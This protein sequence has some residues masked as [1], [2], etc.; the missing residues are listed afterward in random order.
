[1]DVP[2]RL[3]TRGLNCPLPV[4]KAQKALRTMAAGGRLEILTT[5]PKAP[6]DL[7]HLCEAAGHLLI[8]CEALSDHVA[9]IIEKRG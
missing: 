7:T 3:D 4:L 9:V 8:A 5:D 1:M 6:A 2:A